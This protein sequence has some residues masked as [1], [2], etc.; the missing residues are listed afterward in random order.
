MFVTANKNVN[1]RLGAPQVSSPNAGYI[2][3]DKQVEIIG[4]QAGQEIDGNSVWYVTNQNQ[5]LW[6]GG[7]VSTQDLLD[8]NA[9]Q[10]S[11]IDP[12]TL[13]AV[14]HSA[15]SELLSKF[16]FDYPGC[17]GLGV[18]DLNG[19]PALFVF[20]NVLPA[21][22]ITSYIHRGVQL[23]IESELT[24]AITACSGFQD[25][26]VPFPM[27]GTLVDTA[28][29]SQDAYGTRGAFIQINSVGSYLLTCY[30][31]ACQSLLSGGI[32]NFSGSGTV[33]IAAPASGS[34]TPELICPVYEGTLDPTHDYAIIDVSEYAD[35]FKNVI[36]NIGPFT[37]FYQ[38]NELTSD[39]NN[40]QPLFAFGA[41]S[42]RKVQGNIKQ[43]WTQ[44][45]TVG[46]GG[47]SQDIYGLIR[48]TNTMQLGDSGGPVVDVNNKLVG[49]IVAIDKAPGVCCYIMPVGVLF[50]NQGITLYT[51]S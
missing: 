2:A 5:F 16:K 30:H 40:N 50:L 7:F 35:D 21:D 26:G 24:G 20:F 44:G 39:L 48:A 27:G 10:T 43:G 15:M 49:Y 6:S 32:M 22:L 29:S 34:S 46:Y 37:D 38:P 28:I 42:A 47:Y 36:P 12:D 3:I 19:S 4:I 8:G 41:T 18:G 51:K 23:V 25:Q 17:T 9:G 13:L 45:V 31:V 1:I 33:T 11:N 14:Y